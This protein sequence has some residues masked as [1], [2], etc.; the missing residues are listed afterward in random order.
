MMKIQHL[1]TYVG[2]L[3]LFISTASLQA[4]APVRH[5]TLQ[6]LCDS[7]PV[8]PTYQQFQDY[9]HCT[10]EQGPEQIAVLFA[11]I[12]QKKQGKVTLRYQDDTVLLLEDF[13]AD[14]TE[15]RFVNIAIYL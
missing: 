6:Q 4:A 9:E 13:V 11:N 5:M 1:T 15:A 7:L 2:L 14:D 10:K 3:S 12:Y 8:Q